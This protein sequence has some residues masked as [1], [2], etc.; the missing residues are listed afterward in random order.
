[1]QL[2]H[3]PP[4]EP[5]AVRVGVVHVPLLQQPDAQLLTSQHG[6]GAEGRHTQAPLAH[7]WSLVQALPPPHLQ[8][9]LSQTS[10][11]GS[12]PEQTSQASPPVPQ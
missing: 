3:P 7:S 8:S 4:P 10:P 2:V 9:P 1:M 5:H 12:A 11:L 6:A